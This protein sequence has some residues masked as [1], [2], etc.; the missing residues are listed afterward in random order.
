MHCVPEET[1]PLP[2]P[3]LRSWDLAPSAIEPCA[4]E[5][6]AGIAASVDSAILPQQ[7]YKAT[8]ANM[9]STKIGLSHTVISYS[10]DH[11]AI[12]VCID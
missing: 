4:R 2:W 10:S 7:T 1:C 8:L 6:L 12:T 3:C 11:I 9:S 5:K